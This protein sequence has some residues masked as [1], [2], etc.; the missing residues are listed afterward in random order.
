MIW[1]AL[2]WKLSSKQ[3]AIVN[4][5]LSS[6]R[7]A[8]CKSISLSLSFMVLVLKRTVMGSIGYSRQLSEADLSSWDRHILTVKSLI[9]LRSLPSIP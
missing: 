6:S 4:E 1:I 9:L 5:E 8:V 3:S 7:A 2:G